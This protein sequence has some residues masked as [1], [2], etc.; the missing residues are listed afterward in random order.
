MSQMSNKFWKNLKKLK[1]IKIMVEY[2]CRSLGLE[3][4]KK[5]E[6]KRENL[7]EIRLQK[8]ELNPENVG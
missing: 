6:E 4:Q 2:F 8:N 7:N 5:L 3:I 1:K